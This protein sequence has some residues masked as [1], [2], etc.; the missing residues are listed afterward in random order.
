M[1]YS[2]DYSITGTTAEVLEEFKKSYSF[3]YIDSYILAGAIGF[4][5][6][7]RSTKPEKGDKSIT[8]PRSVLLRRKDK[9]DFLF[10][11]FSLIEF[12]DLEQN[13]LMRIVFGDDEIS[14]DKRLELFEEYFL[15]G[16]EILKDLLTRNSYSSEIDKIW[17]SIE[18][19]T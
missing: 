18:S 10:Q 12:S 3:D 5:N 2:S 16:L 8:I 14:I 1:R 17:D 7:L 13:E 6:S 9:I 11:L 19:L 15:G 4:V